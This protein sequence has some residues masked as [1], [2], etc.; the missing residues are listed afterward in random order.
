MTTA[1]APKEAWLN[2]EYCAED[3]PKIF[4][5]HYENAPF[6]IVLE[7]GQFPA[8]KHVYGTN[9]CHLGLAVDKR[10]NRVIV[11]S[12]IDNLVKGAAGQAIQNMNLMCG[13][14]ETAGLTMGAVWP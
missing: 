7:P 9:Y 11:V 10:T 5:A 4:Q 14:D 12:A 3:L 8:T 13:F 6:V 2:D 1:Y